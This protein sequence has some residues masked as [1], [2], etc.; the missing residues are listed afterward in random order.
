MSLTR[1]ILTAVATLT[2]S[3]EVWSTLA[4]MYASCTRARSVQTRMTFATFK[5]GTQ[6]VAEYYSKMRGYADELATS[7]HTLGDEEFM[8]YLFAGF[9]EDF[10][11]VVSAAV[12]CVEPITPTDLYSQLLSHELCCGRHSNGSPA[13]YS[14]VNAAMQG[15]D[16]PGC[17][18]NCGRARGRGGRASG[19]AAH[20]RSPSRPADSSERPRCQIC[21][22]PS[23]TANI[24]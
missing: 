17:F 2:T 12:A 19:T 7:G 15:R 23:H 11:S 13:S 22:R 9:D 20:S 8:S 16:G 14:S 10:D 6:S 4:N 18:N 3:A 5:K 1:E 21:L 24:C